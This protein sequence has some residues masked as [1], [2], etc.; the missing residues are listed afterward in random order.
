LLNVFLLI[1][2]IG[3]GLIFCVGHNSTESKYTQ[4][5]NILGLRVIYSWHDVDKDFQKIPNSII[6]L[7][8]I[9]DHKAIS[10]Q[11]DADLN[12]DTKFERYLLKNGQLIVTE[13][14]I[15]VW[16]SPNEWKVDQFSLADSNNDGVTDLNFSLWKAGNFGSS[17]PFWIENNDMSIKNHFFVL[18]YENDTMRHVWGSSNLA[19]PNCEFQIADVDDDGIN[20][21]IVIEGNYWNIHECKGEYVAV[22]KWNDWGFTNQWR[23]ERGK[24]FD[25]EIVNFDETNYIW[26][27]SSPW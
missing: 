12:G 9:Q 25:L 7:R 20:E 27:G 13:D 23:S 4:F 5:N 18:N 19:L 8:N 21:L 26:V 14:I 16:Q 11:A 3:V 2:V 17:Q 6:Y 1:F 22:W 15:M 10:T 24:Y